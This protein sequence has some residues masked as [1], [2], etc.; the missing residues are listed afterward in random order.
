MKV[1]LS[2]L[3]LQKDELEDEKMKFEKFLEQLQNAHKSEIENVNGRH[4]DELKILQEQITNTQTKLEFANKEFNKL[5]AEN[6][7]ERYENLIKHIKENHE[8][9]LE[10]LQLDYDNEHIILKGHIAKI[11][12][13]MVLA[14]NEWNKLKLENRQDIEALLQNIQEFQKLYNILITAYHEEINVKE[15]IISKEKQ[16]NIELENK[17]KQLLETQKIEMHD[18]QAKHKLEIEDIEYEMLKT[19]TELQN[20]LDQEKKLLETMYKSKITNL[21]NRYNEEVIRLQNETQLEI[22]QI[23]DDCKKSNL[24]TETQLQEKYDRSCAR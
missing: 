7:E 24:L 1:Q 17:M 10:N 9:E 23:K 3:K 22:E 14:R 2:K 21:E 5:K 19:I 4:F 6:L 11:K 20:K 13:E 12:N 8:L 16:A 15:E 18:L